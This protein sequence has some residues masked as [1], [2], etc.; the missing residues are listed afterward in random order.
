[1]KELLSEYA[2]Q[3]R[4]LL[5]DSLLSP[6]ADLG[7]NVSTAVVCWWAII[8][9]KL[10]DEQTKTLQEMKRERGVEV[11]MK[12]KRISRKQKHGGPPGFKRK[13]CAVTQQ[14]P[15]YRKRKTARKEAATQS[16]SSLV[17]FSNFPVVSCRAR[18]RK[19]GKNE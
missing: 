5:P 13:R 15:G 2:G 1:M 7:D 19:P 4:I 8:Q 17:V 12:R 16:S 3:K 18:Q 10:I 6:V 14:R 9:S 11:E